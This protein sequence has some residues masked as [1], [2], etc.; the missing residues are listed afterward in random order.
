MQ[1]KSILEKFKSF[2]YNKWM[3]GLFSLV[4]LFV[5]ISNVIITKST[6]NTIYYTIS[7][8]P[9]KN[10]ALILGTSKYTSSGNTNLFFKYRIS[11]AADLYHLGKIKHIIVSGDNRVKNYN[12]PR[13]MRNSLIALGVPYEAITLDFAGFRT[14]D[15]VVRCKKVFG[16]NKVI[17]ISQTS[18]LQRALFIAHKYD[19]DAIGFSAQ[20]PPGN[21]STKTNIREYFAKSKAIIDLYIIDKEPKFLGK[22]E[23]INI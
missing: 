5:I 3:I 22:K 19:M 18:H 2:L 16:Q 9:E 10:V 8:T 11:A 4:I 14:L 7:N 17:I 21:Y 1:F 13:Q 15:S 20:D 23:I 6:E 12:E